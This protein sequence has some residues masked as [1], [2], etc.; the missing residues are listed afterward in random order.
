[1]TVESSKRARAST[2]AHGRDGGE[3]GVE[4]DLETL[5]GDVLF[6]RQT[7]AYNVQHRE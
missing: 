6:L 2:A 5:D 7:Q 1:M 4:T 3:R